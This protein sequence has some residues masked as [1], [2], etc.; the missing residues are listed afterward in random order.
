VRIIKVIVFSTMNPTKLVLHFSEL[1]TIFYTFY[2][3]LQ[4]CNTIEDELCTGTPVTFRSLTHIPLYCTKLSG[5]TWG[6]AMPPLAV[7]AARLRPIPASR[8]L[9]RP[10]KR[11]GSTRSLARGQGWPWF[12]RRITDEGTRRRPAVT[13]AATR[14]DGEEDALLGN[15]QPWRC[16]GS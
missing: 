15:A 14:G 4:N 2:K 3:F 5:K 6:I 10:G 12:A 1:S 8:R 9:S 13:A 16:N 7:G 11:S